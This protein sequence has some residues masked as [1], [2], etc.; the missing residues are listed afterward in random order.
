MTSIA[1]AEVRYNVTAVLTWMAML[2]AI[3]FI[4]AVL[5]G[6]ALDGLGAVLSYSLA[7]PLLLT[8]VFLLLE[9]QEKRLRQFATLPLDFRRIAMARILRVVMVQGLTFGIM[10][11]I[12][13][14]TAVA[15]G[16]PAGEVLPSFTMGFS[17][18]GL[19]L[20]AGLLVTLLHDLGGGRLVMIAY[21]TL[22]LFTYTLAMVMPQNLASLAEALAAWISSPEGAGS[23]LLLVLALVL[24]DLAV[25][26]PTRR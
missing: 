25:F 17:A 2:I 4:P 13:V 15:A 12:V 10:G 1:S 3:F 19:A 26:K 16:I 21:S 23:V 22:G 8:H 6:S 24:L 5:G 18:A 11:L 14:L 7:I 20:A 9:G